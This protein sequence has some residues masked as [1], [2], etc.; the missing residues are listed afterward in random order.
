MLARER[1]Q[2]AKLYQ[3]HTRMMRMTRATVAFLAFIVAAFFAY[4]ALVHVR[5]LPLHAFLLC[6]HHTGP[7]AAAL[8]RGSA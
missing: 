7:I 2:I 1:A 4:S 8:S 6:T 3:E 5:Y